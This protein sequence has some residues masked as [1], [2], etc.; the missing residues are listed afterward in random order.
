MWTKQ[1][2]RCGRMV[3]GRREPL[4]DLISNRVVGVGL[5][6]DP[7]DDSAGDKDGSPHRTDWDHQS[8]FWG[9]H[10]CREVDEEVG[11]FHLG[12]D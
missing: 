4:P 12:K 7:A 1:M 9:I 6:P 2:H 5:H 8:R 11:V 3:A 10:R